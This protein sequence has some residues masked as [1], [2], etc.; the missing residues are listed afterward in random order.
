M[1]KK[2]LPPPQKRKKTICV[3]EAYAALSKKQTFPVK[4]KVC[5]QP[6]LCQ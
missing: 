6:E 1:D 5:V 3:K 4:K 2:T